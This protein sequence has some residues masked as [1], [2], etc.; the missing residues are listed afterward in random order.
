MPFAGAGDD[1]LPELVGFLQLLAGALSLGDVLDDALV[2]EQPPGRV[3]H[4]AGAL[5]D[6]DDLAAVAL[7]LE[8]HVVDLALALEFLEERAA[9]LR[10]DVDLAHVDGHEAL[11][12]REAQQVEQGGIGVE[13]L[14]RER[15]AV[16]PDGHALEEG[17]VA[18]LGFADDAP[19]GRLL[20][21]RANRGDEAGEVVGVLQDVVVEARLHRGDR[22]LLA[23]GAGAE[24]DRK[25][26]APFADPAEK[27]ERVD[28]ARPVIGDDDI[29]VGCFDEVIE[30]AA[31]SAPG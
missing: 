6:R 3:A 4:R 14:T 12:R 19:A 15:G 2:V 1:L 20:E 11:A 9:R 5:A 25:I 31:G 22:E 26:G 8:L 27:V 21:R 10:V 13:D 23:S 24:Q 7:P 18:S 16:E 17:P 29:E 30:P 28:P